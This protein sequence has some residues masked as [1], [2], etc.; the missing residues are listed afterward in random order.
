[1]GQI[2]TVKRC[3]RCLLALLGLL[4]A[5]ASAGDVPYSLQL[6]ALAQHY[7]RLCRAERLLLDAMSKEFNE[8]HLPMPPVTSFRAAL[9]A[10]ERRD[11]ELVCLGAAQQAI[12]DQQE[13]WKAQ[14]AGETR[15]APPEAAPPP[16][17]SDDGR[18]PRR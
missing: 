10:G 4:A 6:S 5:P 15:S 14:Q 1:M 17:P 16:P 18:R 3:S 13:A 12:D 7:F 2:A 11:A 8:K 9:P